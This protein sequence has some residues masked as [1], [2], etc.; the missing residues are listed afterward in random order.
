MSN[1][2]VAVVVWTIDPENKKRYL[3][4]HNK[5]FAGYEDEWTLCFGGVEPGEAALEAAV[6]EVREEYGIEDYEAV[7]DL[8]YS[9]EWDEHGRREVAR[10]FAV[11]VADISSRIVLDDESIG[12]DW[13]TLQDAL[14]I[15]KYEDESKS[16]LLVD[17]IA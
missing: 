7:Q 15:M 1:E 14:N 5:P 13:M 8:N 9:I 4:R 2:T 12:Y 6:R 16:L 17:A 11:R 3:L 10:F